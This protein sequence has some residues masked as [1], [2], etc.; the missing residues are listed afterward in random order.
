MIQKLENILIKGSATKPILIDA[1][2]KA[3]TEPKAVVVFCHGFKGF[4][5]WGPFNKIA[6]YFAQQDFVFV[7]FNF[8]YNGTTPSSPV[9]FKDLKA[10]G[11][12]NFCKELD[13]LSLVLD[14]IK[15]CDILK[16]EIDKSN[17]SLFGHS[18][19]GGIAILKTAEDKHIVKIIS[20]ASPANF[21]KTLPTGAK[22]EKWRHKNVAYIFNGRTKQNM[23]LYFQ[24]YENCKANN[25]RLNIKNAVSKMLIPHL[26]V[27][28]S[29][30]PTVL[31]SEAENIKKW[32][33]NTNLH[34]IKGAN[35]VLGGF[36][37]YDL[38][39][40]PEHLQ[41]AIDSTIVFLKQKSG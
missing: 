3:N 11:E 28:G 16:E 40:F 22:L 36:H 19:G 1:T 35:H 10:F 21:F 27:H 23:P 6:A 2:F 31:L 32:N 33:P 12:N 5:D 7:K 14:W 13:D 17:I 38:E 26:V 24:F 15:T 37:P 25:Q 9:D 4:K 30:D 39:K 41:E 34:I 20:W 8:S 29:E 18:R